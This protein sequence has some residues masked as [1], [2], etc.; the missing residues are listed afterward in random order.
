MKIKKAFLSTLL[1]LFINVTQLFSQKIT[2]PIVGL[3]T[4]AE[5]GYEI[6]VDWNDSF[7]TENTSFVYN[8]KLARISAILSGNAYSLVK[9]AISNNKLSEN[10]LHKTYKAL[11]ISEDA[12]EYHYD[13]DYKNEVYGMNQTGFSFAYKKSGNKTIVF[14]TI[15]GTTFNTN[16]WSSNL[17]MSDMNK[18]DMTWHEGFI[19]SA[20]QVYLSFNLFLLK[21][22]I[23][24]KDSYLLISGHSRGAAVANII[25]YKIAED[26]LFNTTRVFS[27]PI[28]C[29]NVTTKDNVN[30]SKYNFIWNIGN[31]EDLV[32]QVPPNRN[33]WKFKRFGNNLIIP[34]RWNTDTETYENVY[35]PK[36]NEL[37][38]NFMHR[39]LYPFRLGNYVP[40]LVARL[41]TNFYDDIQGYNSNILGARYKAEKGF[42]FA[43]YDENEGKGEGIRYVVEEDLFLRKLYER[44]NKKHNNNLNVTLYNI[45]DMHTTEAYLSWLLCFEENELFKNIGSSQ[46]TISGSENCIIFD[47]NGNTL[48]KYKDGYL[49]LFTSKTPIG[50]F[51]LFGKTFIGFP[52]NEDFTVII[53]KNSLLPNKTTIQIEHYDW[54]GDLTEILPKQ[55]IYLRT[56]KSFQFNAGK[57]TFEETEIKGVIQNEMEKLCSGW[58]FYISPQVHASTKKE[59]SFGLNIGTQNLHTTTFFTKNILNDNKTLS[60]GLGNQHCVLGRF[61]MNDGFLWNFNWKDDSFEQIPSAYLTLSYQPVHKFQIFAGVEFWDFCK[62]RFGIK[63]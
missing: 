37:Y 33:T 41:L 58:G 9:D 7:F 59:L 29:P 5:K 53:Q 25:S 34:C 50:A 35:L 30:E 39:E 24:P 56:R 19:K 49:D 12:I 11:G 36:I 45:I 6:S 51:S 17:N 32:L 46:L 4:A 55:K 31:E 61:Y 8:H 3:I 63:F 57:T 2:I 10:P 44:I 21:N 22:Q 28:G 43:L 27:F 15:R 14:L 54:K 40:S 48:L 62:G 23:N 52:A 1:F 18:N 13:I 16:E 42:K 47:K 26:N 38:K 60:I 20:T